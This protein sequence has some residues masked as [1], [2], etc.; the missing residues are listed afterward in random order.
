MIQ[1]QP[2]FETFFRDPIYLK[3]KNS[4]YNYLVR[5]RSVRKLLKGKSGGQIL[6]VG[7]GISPMLTN[8]TPAIRTDFSFQAL[9]LLQTTSSNGRAWR[10]VVCDAT[11]LPFADG[12]MGFVICSEVLEHIEADE[13]VLKEISRILKPGG[14]LV[15]TCPVRPELFGFDDEL[16]GHYRR[17]ET[18]DLIRRLSKYNFGTVKVSSLLGRLEKRLMERVARLY[19]L[20]RGTGNGKKSRQKEFSAIL[21]LIAWIFFP[22]YV[23]LN[24]LLAFLVFIQ[25]RLTAPDRAVTVLIQCNKLNQKLRHF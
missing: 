21:R 15:L 18:N 3:Y 9:Q 2:R 17:Y 19:A 24:G 25:A 20:I 16:V 14:E 13:N 11:A 12:S 6:E 4:L 7:C 22:L 8:S 23:A 5:R 10:G 1:E